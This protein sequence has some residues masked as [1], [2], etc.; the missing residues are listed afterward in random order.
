VSIATIMVL[1]YSDD[2]QPV[3]DVI[4]LTGDTTPPMCL[5]SGCVGDRTASLHDVPTG[6]PSHV[7]EEISSHVVPTDSPGLSKDGTSEDI[8]HSSLLDL[9]EMKYRDFDVSLNSSLCLPSS[10]TWEPR[11]PPTPPPPRTKRK[12]VTFAALPEEAIDENP[13]TRQMPVEALAPPIMGNSDEVEYLELAPELVQGSGSSPRVDSFHCLGRHLPFE[14]RP[15]PPSPHPA[16]WPGKTTQPLPLLSS[17]LALS[18]SYSH[19]PEASLNTTRNSKQRHRAR[20]TSSSP[21]N[22]AETIARGNYVAPIMAVGSL[23]ITV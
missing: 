11:R 10:K 16:S 3:L 9:A 2:M 1:T 13:E 21:S 8:S 19:R 18:H 20:A 7:G 4:D 15:S 12:G 5:P 17:P 14:P 22:K 6:S 23:Y